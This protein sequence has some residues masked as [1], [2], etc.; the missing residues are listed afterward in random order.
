MPESALLPDTLGGYKPERELYHS[1]KT[2]VYQAVTT[3]T[4]DP[5]VIKVP[6]DQHDDAAR[7]RIRYE[8]ALLRDLVVEGIPQPIDVGEESMLV[9]PYVPGTTLGQYLKGLEEPIP[10]ENFVEIGTQLARILSQVHHRGIAHRDLNPQNILIDPDTFTVY[11]IDFGIASRFDLQSPPNVPPAQLEGT[12][13]YISPE[14][15]GRMNRGVDYRTDLYSLGITLYEVL[16]GSVPFNSQDPLELVHAHLALSPKPVSQ[17]RTDAP[18]IIWDIMLR[19]LAKD[20]E[21]RY[22]SAEGLEHDLGFV[23]PVAKG[24]KLAAEVVLGE[25][26]HPLRFEISQRLY[27]RDADREQILQAFSRIQGAGKQALFL[28]GPSGI[29]KS[30]LVAEVHRPMTEARGLYLAG[31]FDQLQRNITHFAWRQALEKLATL[32][33]SESESILKVWRKQLKEAI[34]GNGRIITDLSPGMEQ[35]LGPQPPL[36]EL[37]GAGTQ[38]R[39]HLVMK[40]F[41]TVLARPEHPV[42]VFLD[43]WQWADQ[44]SIALLK[45]LF[46]DPDLQHIMFLCAYRD[47]EVDEGHPFVKMQ[48]ELALAVEERTLFELKTLTLAPLQEVHIRELLKDTFRQEG[49]Y[50]DTLANRLH[51]KTL[52]NAF[53]V[54]QLL[55]SLY[56]Q[57]VIQLDRTATGFRWQLDLSTLDDLKIT[58]NVVGFMVEKVANLP[59]QSQSVLQWAAIIGNTFSVELLLRVNELEPDALQA[60]LLPALQEGLLV[61]LG[62]ETS[63]YTSYRFVHDSV[64]KAFYELIPDAERARRHLK[65]AQRWEEE[66]TESSSTNQLFDVT[67]AYNAGATEISESVLKVR[68]AALNLKAALRAQYASAYETALEYAQAG[69]NLLSDSNWQTD[70]E[71]IRDLHRAA[72]ENAYF[73][74][75][76]ESTQRWLQMLMDKADSTLDKVQALEIKGEYHKAQQEYV[77]A[78]E[79]GMEVVALQGIKLKSPKL[80][81]VIIGILGAKFRLDRVGLNNLL[82]LKVTDNPEHE[83]ME[84]TLLNLGIVVYF[85]RPEYLPILAPAQVQVMLKNG[86]TVYSPYTYMS[87]A[88]NMIAGLGNIDY[89]YKLGKL[90]EELAQKLKPTKLEG[91]IG[92]LH[93]HFVRHWLEPVRDVVKAQEE[94]YFRCLEIGDF[95]FASYA[96]VSGSKM[97]YVAGIPLREVKEQ[98]RIYQKALREKLRIPSKY[99]E[100]LAVH[101]LSAWLTEDDTELITWDGK[102]L[103]EEALIAEF[104]EA[105]NQTALAAIQWGRMNGHL[106]L[107]ELDKAWEAVLAFEENLGAVTATVD[108]VQYYYAKSLIQA[109]RYPQLNSK[110]K[111]EARKFIKSGSKKLKKWAK[112]TPVNFLHKHLFLQAELA[113]LSGNTT[114]AQDLYQR[115]QSQAQEAK[116]LQ[117]AAMAHERSASLCREQGNNSLAKYHLLEA[118]SLYRRWQ[119]SL[120]VRQLETVHSGWLGQQTRADT[121]SIE[122]TTATTNKFD[123][124]L[125]SII[126]S[127]QVISGEIVLAVLLEKMLEVVMENAGAQ[128]AVLLFQNQQKLV[129][130]AE[131]DYTSGHR[132]FAQGL[133]LDEHRHLAPGAIVYYVARSQKTLVLTDPHKEGQYQNDPYLSEKQ[134]RNVLGLPLLKQ[135]QLLG[136]LYLEHYS[137]PDMFVQERLSVLNLL[138][139]QIAISLENALLYDDL[140]GKVRER[141]RE[142]LQQKELIEEQKFQIEKTNEKVMSSIRYAKDIQSAMLLPLPEV[143]ALVPESFI[144]FKPRDVVSGDFYWVHEQSGKTFIAAVDCTG[145]GVPGA[146]MSMIGNSLLD[147][148]LTKKH[149]ESP[150]AILDELQLSVRKA[151]RQQDSQNRDGMDLALAVIDP[152]NKQLL[153]SGARNPLV[154]MQKGETHQVKADRMSIGGSASSTRKL[155]TFSLHTV[156][157]AEEDGTPIPTT[158]YLFSDGFQDQFGGTEKAKYST[159]RFRGLLTEIAE[160]PMEQQQK[161]LDEA[162]MSWMHTGHEEQI[163]DVLVMGVKV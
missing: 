56:Q 106:I 161:K 150:E 154:Y 86:H 16:T 44:A 81:N 30:A 163:D 123:I 50:L 111:G 40:R 122:G 143:Q 37:D 59:D 124:D 49:D 114:K 112:K 152:K 52:G 120:K 12:L 95:E 121:I 97:S 88:L 139:S 96:A 118:H 51:A 92:F 38:N 43:D 15:T 54:H 46:L 33:L 82:K 132:A 39:F 76:N 148:I 146:L 131:I 64:Q 14:Q 157:L 147:E 119:N 144:F 99:T 13:N 60:R 117:D 32:L 1:S 41:F 101:L 73:V 149:I 93:R 70:Y 90:G 127:S 53:F 137:A 89:G 130:E 91:R 18:D 55:K 100:Y 159:K 8:T 133:V 129:V 63:G 98:A 113:R 116:M 158:F 110:E 36:T 109:R 155:G 29:G 162:L 102:E 47:N 104:K 138:S 28:A 83:A 141:T 58:E 103:D 19:L 72:L 27:G 5:V 10:F 65:L 160:S 20:P 3:A 115:V 78:F 22:Q 77:E 69:M 66:L 74:G 151:L 105:K 75:G 125:I 24:E 135:G 142:V 11:L 84:R 145:H 17:F 61:P 85:S 80:I 2:I 140:E 25:K 71:L 35:I 57:K 156:P 9:R 94:L 108:L 45:E 128:R 7:G 79:V 134:P 153:F 4:Q 136:V 126:K 107:D 62:G 26:D 67:N 31:K 42:V 21:N 87:F 48:S 34:G 68:V 6:A 23:L